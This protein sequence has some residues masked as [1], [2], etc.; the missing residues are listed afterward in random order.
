LL[1]LVDSVAWNLAYLNLP[2]SWE[3]WPTCYK[4]ECDWVCVPYSCV[5]VHWNHRKVMYEGRI[6]GKVVPVHSRTQATEFFYTYTIT[7]D[8]T[9]FL[10]WNCGPVITISQ[11]LW[12][13]ILCMQ[14]L[15][16]GSDDSMLFL[17]LL[18]FWTSTRTKHSTSEIGSLTLIRS[19]DGE[20]FSQLGSTQT[21]SPKCWMQ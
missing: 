1:T 9:T 8:A 4:V 13:N 16:G 19:K 18:V 5:N 10:K 6:K 11:N 17:G 7:R 21:D 20:T 12:I 3:R 2:V 14:L 15:G